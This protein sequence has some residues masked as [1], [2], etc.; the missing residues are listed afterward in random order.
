M[1]CRLAAAAPVHWKMS[2]PIKGSKTQQMHAYKPDHFDPDSMTTL[3]PAMMKMMV[4]ILSSVSP[5]SQ[6]CR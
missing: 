5:S 3:T 2:I 4:S 6:E 1:Q